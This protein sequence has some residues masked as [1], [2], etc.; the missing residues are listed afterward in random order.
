VA[1]LNFGCGYN[2]LEGY[3]NA[4]VDPACAP[5]VLIE[6]NDL[7][8]FKDGEFEEI[9]ANDVLEHVPHKYTMSVLF[10]WSRMLADEG[11]LRLQTSYLYGLIDIMRHGADFE[12]EFNFNMCLFGNQNHPGDFHY[13][14]F[15]HRTLK[16][17]LISAGFD[18]G[19]LHL[20]DK[21]LISCSAV[22]KRSWQSLSQFDLN[23]SDFIT[24]IYQELLSRAPE[25]PALDAEYAKLQG[26]E[27][28]ANLIR[29]LVCCHERLYK[30]GATIGDF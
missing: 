9:Y 25:P 10:E 17:F 4:D 16:T 29:T 5:D 7:S 19:T 28:R 2:K 1:K 11:V 22:K 23:D 14:S 12:T 27:S 15:T 18:P 30:I 26:G 13:T 24:F 8:V 20:R 21:W 3:V 6:N